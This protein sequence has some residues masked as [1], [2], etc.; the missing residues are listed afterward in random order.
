VDTPILPDRRG[1]D[2]AANDG[3]L[4]PRYLPRPEFIRGLA[5]T[6]TLIAAVIGLI[7]QLDRGGT[8][9]PV[10]PP[11][12]VVRVVPPPMVFFGDPVSP[13]AFVRG[14]GAYDHARDVCT[15]ESRPNPNRGHWRCN[16]FSGLRARD[17]GRV[18]AAQSGPC[19][20]RV[21]EDG[22]RTWHCVARIAVPE[23]LRHPLRGGSPFYGAALEGNDVCIDEARSNPRQGAWH[24]TLWRLFPPGYDLVPPLETTG[25]CSFRIADQLTG[26][27]S[28]RSAPPA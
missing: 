25:P 9:A 6:V 8:A 5:A 4:R 13:L 27:W 14:K 10:G 7:S 11:P 22:A 20:H 1:D 18:A 17:L 3:T 2:D 12:G 26:A 19:T 16:V 21:V 23:P 24:C 28:C 15:D